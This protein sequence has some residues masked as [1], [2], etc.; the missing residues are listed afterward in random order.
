MQK[1][2][3]PLLLPL[4]LIGA[5]SLACGGDDAAEAPSQ[6]P[7]AQA[8]ADVAD[9]PTA[10]PPAAPRNDDAALKTFLL[11]TEGTYGWTSTSS[12]L[13]YD[14]FPT[15]KAHVQGPDG[16]ATMWEGDWTLAN[17][18]LTITVPELPKAEFTVERQQDNLLLN[19]AVWTRYKP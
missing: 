2:P 8:P 5:F 12:E 9:T 18:K 4:L 7:A 11:S 10:P 13:S 14:F 19:G 1:R 17:G 16:E 15:G 3:S 6:A